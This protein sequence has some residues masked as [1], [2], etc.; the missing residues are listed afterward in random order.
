M[1][2]LLLLAGVLL[3][4]GCG[5]K[6]GSKSSFDKSSTQ[7]NKQT[8]MQFPK[9]INAD[10]IATGSIPVPWQVSIT[11]A[12]TIRFVTED[13][14]RLHIAQN[15]CVVKNVGN[16]TTYS[17]ADKNFILT[18]STESCKKGGNVKCSF[19]G[20]EYTGCG[21]YTVNKELDGRWILEQY[22]R[23]T[24]DVKKFAS[25]PE[26]NINT[27]KGR[28]S[29]NDG[30]NNFEGKL[31]VKGKTLEFSS[32][33]GTERYCENMEVADIIAQKVS[34]KNCG[35]SFE[36][37]RLNLYLFDDAMLVFVKKSN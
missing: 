8:N 28:V 30:C 6:T 31:T 4:M 16:T 2:K 11:N 22:D 35:Y 27:N 25:V 18:K 14:V 7:A 23:K 36:N 3:S 32:L 19:L 37:S 5:S 20:K 26:I 34:S 24:F 29:G 13:G 10:Y 33:A 21:D 12:D 17:N 15:Y 9:E 1:K